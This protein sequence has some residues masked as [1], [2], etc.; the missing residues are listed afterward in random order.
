IE[1]LKNSISNFY[2]MISMKCI[3]SK[4]AKIVIIV[5][6]ITIILLVL[7]FIFFINQNG[8]KKKYE[9]YK[10][11]P[12][13]EHLGNY[14]ITQITNK[15]LSYNFGDEFATNA[16]RRE[17][18][19]DKNPKER[20]DGHIYFDTIKRNF[21]IKTFERIDPKDGHL[22]YDYIE[23]LNYDF[24]GNIIQKKGEY[25]LKKSPGI[26]LKDEITNFYDWRNQNSTFFVEYFYEQNF[27]WR[28]LNP[29][30]NFGS[31]NGSSIDWYWKGIAYLKLIMIE[32]DINFKIET[33]ST[34]FGY[35]FEISLYRLNSE[36]AFI[37]I[38][39]K[40]LNDKDK[41]LYLITR[42]RSPE[43]EFY[44]IN[45]LIFYRTIVE[46]FN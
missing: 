40:Y 20:I 8:D 29:L 10:L 13:L 3:V 35:N 27:Q 39:D 18:Y 2:T 14:K 42:D 38:G 16:E 45:Y 26:I 44:K 28:S 7:Y 11:M 41:G 36:M 34:N 37:Y 17:Y 31:P 5:L 43:K 22:L 15:K 32:N 33:M 23:W 19:K 9:E 30:R 6:G 21:W 1:N 46:K 24:H 12:E 4:K 25:E